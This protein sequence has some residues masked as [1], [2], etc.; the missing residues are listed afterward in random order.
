MS[1]AEVERA[2]ARARQFHAKAPTQ[3]ADAPTV[4]FAQVALSALGF[5]PGPAD[6]QMG[7]KTRQALSAYQAKAGLRAD[8]ALTDSVL[9]RLRTDAAPH[10][11]RAPLSR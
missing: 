5:E 1:S 2:G 10:V 7:Q 6:G 8:A 3:F 4:R 9:D 11:A